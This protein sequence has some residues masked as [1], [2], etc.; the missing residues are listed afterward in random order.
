MKTLKNILVLTILFSL[1]VLYGAVLAH[2]GTKVPVCVKA[3]INSEGFANAALADPVKDVTK[4]VKK[5]KT[6]T[7]NCDKPSLT[8]V[9]TS[10][11]MI[12]TGDLIFTSGVISETKQ[13]YM[14]GR[15][16]LS[17]GRTTVMAQYHGWNRSWG[18]LAKRFREQVEDFVSMNGVK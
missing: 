4:Q 2:A 3:D 5:S 13:R 6:L 9:I 14:T 17:D 7:L 1:M 10:R 8:V 11:G 16:E 18:Y 15:L 12:G